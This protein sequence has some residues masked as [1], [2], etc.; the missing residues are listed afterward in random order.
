[1]ESSGQRPTAHCRRHYFKISKYSSKIRA[2]KHSTPYQP[3]LRSHTMTIAEKIH[4]QVDQASPRTLRA[5]YQMLHLLDFNQTKHTRAARTTPPSLQPW[6][7]ASQ[8]TNNYP[9]PSTTASQMAIEA[10][11]ERV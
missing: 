5:I 8:I 2:V 4:R 10:R 3:H 7:R 9:A 1:M 11:L 6:Q